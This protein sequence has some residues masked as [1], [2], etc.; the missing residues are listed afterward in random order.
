MPTTYIVRQGD[1]WARI[2]KQFGFV[3]YKVLYDHPANAE[4]KAKRPNPNVLRPGDRI[5][6]PDITTKTLDVASGK[7]HTLQ[8][9]SGRKALR[10]LLAGHDGEPLAGVEYELEVGEP[11]PRRGST[12]GAGKLEQLVPG[13]LRTATLTIADRV[14]ELRLGHLNPV[15]EAKDGDMSGVQ[16]RLKNLGYDPGPADGSYGPR[17]RAALAIFQS[18]EGLDVSGEVD[19]ATLDKLEEVHGC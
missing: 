8:V 4:L 14:L 18:D 7:K 17:T 9:K 6:V 3:D 16:G 2:A 12:D 19:D 13:L 1:C 5:E 11:E 15:A 10:L